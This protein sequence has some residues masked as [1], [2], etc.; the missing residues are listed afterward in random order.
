MSGSDL[1][2]RT[3]LLV[4][5][6]IRAVNLSLGRRLMGGQNGSC[7]FGEGKRTIGCAL[8]NQFWRP[9]KVSF[10]WSEP[11]SAKEN[12]RAKTKGGGKR[13]IIGGGGVQNSYW[14]GR[15]FMVCFPLP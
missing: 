10:A 7:D 9:Q 4:V 3:F 6:T 1:D 2:E 14:E 8:Q 15:G 11:V 12:N 13:I 5:L